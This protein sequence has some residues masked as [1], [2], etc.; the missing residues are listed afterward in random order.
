MHPYGL[1]GTSP[2]YQYLPHRL[3]TVDLMINIK[4]SKNLTVLS[5][6]VT[7]AS[8]TCCTP[9][10]SPARGTDAIA[11]SVTCATIFARWRA[12][13]YKNNV[14]SCELQIYIIGASL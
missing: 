8:L 1:G 5:L 9:V 11:R 4:L 13:C 14:V 7:L 12:T 6:V 10:S 3:T 2:L